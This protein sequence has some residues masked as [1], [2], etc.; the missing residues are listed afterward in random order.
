MLEVEVC[1]T[2][3]VSI[4]ETEEKSREVKSDV[5]GGHGENMTTICPASWDRAIGGSSP[6]LCPWNVFSVPCS[7]TGSCS[8]ENM[9]CLGRA[10]VV[11]IICMVYVTEPR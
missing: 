10:C 9:S 4:L 7:H 3:C 11:D 6:I 8:K 2:G 1:L 5:G